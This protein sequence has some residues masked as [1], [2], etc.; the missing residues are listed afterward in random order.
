[1][2][3]MG[4]DSI[5]GNLS[6]DE[7]VDNDLKEI[8]YVAGAPTLDVFVKV[9][10]SC[11]KP[12]RHRFY[13]EDDTKKRCDGP[14]PD[15]PTELALPTFVIDS[16]VT[17]GHGL[18]DGDR[19]LLVLWGHAYNFAF[20]RSRTREGVVDALDFH[21]LSTI[22]GRLQA[23]FEAKMG[24]AYLDAPKKL[25]IIGFD[26]CEVA[27]VEIACQLEPFA[28]YLL[29]SQV[30]VPIPG[31]PYDR[32]LDRIAK[33]Q[34]RLMVP[35]EFG[36]YAV[37]RF[38]ESYEA[39]DPTSLTMID[40]SRV[41]E[42]KALAGFLALTLLAAIGDSD[43]RD[44]IV[45]LFYR[46]QVADERAFVDVADLCLSLIR[47]SG[48]AFVV[49]AARALGNFLAESTPL[50]LIGQSATGKGR[51]LIVEHGRNAGD[52]ARLHGI[53][54]YAPHVAPDEDTAE[55][56]ALYESFDFARDTCWSTLVRLLAQL[57]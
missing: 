8:E 54:L 1:M 24:A 46:S 57:G 9:H 11:G 38:C 32:I 28:N 43:E 37:R 15:S 41:G 3:F 10:R 17:A 56:Q 20:G 7:A 25:D 34:G 31:W 30:G 29:A 23:T 4:A 22:L 19:S 27:T 45:E 51:P 40:L 18:H 42:L 12:Q 50:E 2:I 26:A 21:E 33:P 36:S 52:L 6:L 47:E 5:E 48:D 39:V 35:A 53:S 49:E 13:F 16:L 55:T 44:R 14:A